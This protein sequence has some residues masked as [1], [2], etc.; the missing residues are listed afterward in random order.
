MS[1]LKDV[2]PTIAPDVIVEAVSANANW[3]KKNARKA[4][5]VVP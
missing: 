2:R 4:T 5:P 1:P 3:N